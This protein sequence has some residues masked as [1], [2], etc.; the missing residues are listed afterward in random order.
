M[1]DGQE[2][3][4]AGVEA[5]LTREDAL[6]T[7]YRDHAYQMAR[8]DT[9]KRVMAELFAKHTGSSKGKGGSMHL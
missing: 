2:A 6:I 7:G 8:G 4:L 9:A 5:A 3:C 1:Y